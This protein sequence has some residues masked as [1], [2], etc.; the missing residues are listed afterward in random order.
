M[1]TH[2]FIVSFVNFHEQTP[3]CSPSYVN[4]GLI[5]IG[6][7]LFPHT[8][9]HVKHGESEKVGNYFNFSMTHTKGAALCVAPTMSKGKKKEDCLNA[10]HDH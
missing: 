8:H 7:H 6:L 9:P 10:K 5:V 4:L 3:F 1:S 2:P